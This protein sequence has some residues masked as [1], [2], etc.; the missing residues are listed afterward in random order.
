MKRFGVAI[1]CVLDEEDNEK[2]DDSGAGIDDELPGVRK[3]E[4]E[5]ADRPQD[6]YCHGQNE[7]IRMADELRGSIGKAAE[8]EAR[9]VGFDDLLA[10]LSEV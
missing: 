10:G 8:P 9:G 1:L 3:V 6:Q 5:T 7:H 4:V 2:C